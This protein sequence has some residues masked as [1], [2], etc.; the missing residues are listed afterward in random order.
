VNAAVKEEEN[1]I[2]AIKGEHVVC[3]INAIEEEIKAEGK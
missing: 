3:E 1:P 2:G